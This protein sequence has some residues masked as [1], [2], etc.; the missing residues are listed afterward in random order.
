MQPGDRTPQSMPELYALALVCHSVPNRHREPV[1][2]SKIRAGDGPSM[3]A[4]RSRRTSPT[5]LKSRGQCRINAGRSDP[6]GPHG[7]WAAAGPVWQTFPIYS[8]AGAAGRRVSKAGAAP[9]GVDARNLPAPQWRNV[10]SRQQEDH[11]RDIVR[12]A[13][14]R[15]S[16]EEPRCSTGSSLCG[17]P[18][19]GNRHG[20]R[21]HGKKK[22]N[23]TGLYGIDAKVRTAWSYARPS[24]P[25]TRQ[26]VR[27]NSG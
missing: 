26:W 7:H 13:T 14:A 17:T 5:S 19:D 9:S 21:H 4:Q 25:L 22:T 23:G 12:R 20:A 18:P 2:T 16:A 1:S 24:R 10:I 6:N 27:K 3:S 11:Y 15:S 8:Q